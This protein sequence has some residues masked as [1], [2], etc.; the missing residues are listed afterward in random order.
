MHAVPTSV[1]PDARLHPAPAT[2]T[3]ESQTSA[4]PSN[5]AREGAVHGAQH[6]PP[7][8][9][10]GYNGSSTVPHLSAGMFYSPAY[11]PGGQAHHAHPPPDYAHHHEAYP[12]PY[13]AQQAG[14]PFAHLPSH[15]PSAAHHQY[16]HPPPPTDAELVPNHLHEPPRSF[17]KRR[18]E[19]YPTVEVETPPFSLGAPSNWVAQL[20][21]TGSLSHATSQPYLH[22]QPFT[23]G[24]VALPQAAEFEPALP[25]N[26]EANYAVYAPSEGAP[27]QQG[28]WYLP[29]AALYQSAPGGEA[30][31]HP[32]PGR[33]DL[34][35][36][37]NAYVPDSTGQRQ[38]SY[39]PAGPASTGVPSRAS[40]AASSRDRPTAALPR[41]GL[42]PFSRTRLGTP[43]PL[44][45]SQPPPPSSVFTIP[46]P[47]TPSG[48]SSSRSAPP[49]PTL[50]VPPAPSATGLPGRAPSPSLE[51]EG[52]EQVAQ[53]VA[54]ASI[55]RA[56]HE[57]LPPPLAY[58]PARGA[59]GH[60][61]SPSNSKTSTGRMRLTAFS[62]APDRES[63]ALE[64]RDL[65]R[66]R[67]K[68]NRNQQ[69]EVSSVEVLARCATCT[70]V[71][72]SGAVEPRTLARLVLRA[73]PPHL[74]E[75]LERGAT[76]S[77]VVR[78]V[79]TPDAVDLGA[80]CWACLDAREGDEGVIRAGAQ[81]HADGG[82]ATSAPH[83]KSV[84]PAARQ[85]KTY[86]ATLS[87]AIDKLEQLGLEGAADAGSPSASP[88]SSAAL[89]MSPRQM[90]REEAARAEH[91][92]LLLMEPA[93]APAQCKSGWL[94]CDVCDF[95]CGVGTAVSAVP[96][97]PAAPS[98]TVEVICARC[99]ALFRC[100][101]DCGGGG[102]RL[103][104]GRWRCKELF[105][106]FTSLIALTASHGADAFLSSRRTQ[107]LPAVARSQPSSRRGHH[108]G[109][110]FSS[111]C[112][113]TP[114]LI[115]FLP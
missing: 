24:C 92:S 37:F 105:R 97:P 46:A 111:L 86:D 35:Q 2:A 69:K 25:P 18:L 83:R 47:S 61:K 72:P 16:L 78:I 93:R 112:R 89:G 1:T 13:T 113:C 34:P 85:S 107:D 41:T 19:E 91:S 55:R 58:K 28:L 67:G 43:E 96:G 59:A 99:A 63:E 7:S 106:A 60:A 82:T 4:G 53:V 88:G 100:C 51:S 79:R 36:Q 26:L 62:R 103:T 20:D 23:S 5:W 38:H 65:L 68:V 29:D 66:S 33:A 64:E 94:R 3:Y 56:L 27:S 11:A 104:P 31:L 109:P 110:F 73:I 50:P 76:P 71:D 98:F 75:A 44:T 15:P 39:A 81:S 52:D 14:L 42:D 40:S 49:P 22:G 90:E 48:S 12:Q 32:S 84:A 87:A 80:S 54:L 45:S 101:S 6:W 114:V 57:T 8:S 95:I 70:V 108:V 30:R 10:T 9:T 17:Q 77:S 102:G 115:C 74:V 21:G